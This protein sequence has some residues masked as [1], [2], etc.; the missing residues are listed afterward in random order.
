[1]PKFLFTKRIPQPRKKV[2]VRMSPALH[3]ALIKRAEETNNSFNAYCVMQLVTS[4]PAQ[5]FAKI[6]DKNPQALAIR[7]LIR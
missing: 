7:K 2:M 5:A 6:I 3:D 1:M 4:L